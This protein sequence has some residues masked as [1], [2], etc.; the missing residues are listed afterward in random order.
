MVTLHTLQG[1]IIDEMEQYQMVQSQ[2]ASNYER[3]S[4]SFTML[5]RMKGQ[6]SQ[7]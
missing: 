5:R 3:L 2:Q 4:E 1:E 6:G 7:D